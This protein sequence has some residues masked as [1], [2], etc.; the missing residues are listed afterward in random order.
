[1]VVVDF[2]TR[3]NLSSRLAVIMPH[4]LTCIIFIQILFSFDNILLVQLRSIHP[5]DLRITH[6]LPTCIFCLSLAGI[7]TALLLQYPA[8]CLFFFSHGWDFFLHTSTSTLFPSRPSLCGHFLV[9]LSFSSCTPRGLIP[10]SFLTDNIP[11]RVS[12]DFLRVELSFS[13][14]WCS[15]VLPCDN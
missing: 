7:S 13:C 10:L 1:M 5:L 12:M 4:H 15:G 14:V 6:F 8:L 3:H 11:P 9:S 2:N